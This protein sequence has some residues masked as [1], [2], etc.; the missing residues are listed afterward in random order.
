MSNHLIA[1]DKYPG[2]HPVGVGETLRWVVGKAVCMATR[3]ILR[4]YVKLISYVGI[5]VRD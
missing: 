5:K 1:L 2:V 4:T 3:L